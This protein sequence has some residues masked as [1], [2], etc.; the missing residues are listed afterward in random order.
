MFPTC[1]ERRRQPDLHN[2]ATHQ[3][4]PSG[5]ATHRSSVVDTRH[6]AALPLSI[7]FLSLTSRACRRRCR[8]FSTHASFFPCLACFCVCAFL[9]VLSFATTFAAFS[10]ALHSKAFAVALFLAMREISMRVLPFSALSEGGGQI[11][12]EGPELAESAGNM[13]PQDELTQGGSRTWQEES[14]GLEW[15]CKRSNTCMSRY[16][17]DG[18]PTPSLPKDAYR[19]VRMNA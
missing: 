17:W 15:V 3:A 10:L 12:N 2:S 19:K 11:Q 7:F 13:T 9:A 6:W 14:S 16:V 5:R 8:T 18:V 1:L 4:P